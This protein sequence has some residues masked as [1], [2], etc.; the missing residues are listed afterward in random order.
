MRAKNILISGLLLL[1]VAVLSCKKEEETTFRYLTGLPTF[2]LPTYVT[3]GETFTV[4]PAAVTNPD[5]GGYGYYWRRSWIDGKDTTKTIDGSGDGT[6]T[7]STP[8]EIGEYT[9]TCVVFADGFSTSSSSATIYVIDTELETTV[10]GTGILPRDDHFTDPRDGKVYY[11]TSVGGNVWMRNNLGY[12]G[13][14]ESFKSSTAMDFLFGRFY[15]WNEACKACPDGWHLPSEADWTALAAA[16]APDGSFTEGETFSEAA[17]ALMA[18]AKFLDDT[19]WEFWPQ[20]K[21]TNATRLAVLPVGYATSGS[22]VKFTGLNDYAV[23]WTGD[24]R[25]G[26]GLYRYIYVLKNDIFSGDGD[27]DSF[28][29]SVRCVKD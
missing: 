24:S 6:F 14:G 18:N 10:T 9:V 12:S 25:D 17:G 3:M 20:V 4:T 21:I 29:A 22:Q 23:L 1:S 19:M 15:T 5:G 8:D 28:R 2:S 26:K 11:T 13:S 16:A 7:F 27:P